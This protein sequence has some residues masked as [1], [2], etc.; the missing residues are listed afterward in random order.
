METTATLP[1]LLVKYELDSQ[2]NLFANYAKGNQPTQGHA[3]FFQ[4]TPAQQ[5]IASANGV[6]P[7]APEAEVVN[8]ELGIKHRE[9]D[10]RWYVNAS[11]YYLEWTGRGRVSARCRST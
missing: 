6:N 4:L 3:T 2:T 5:T 11:L 1:R 7:T 10:G 8:D 9:D